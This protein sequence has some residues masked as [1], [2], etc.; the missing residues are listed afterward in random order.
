MKTVLATTPLSSV[1]FYFYITLMTVLKQCLELKKKEQYITP[2]TDK[3]GNVVEQTK[4]SNPS[5]FSL[6][7]GLLG[8]VYY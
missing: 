4:D 8:L 3:D 1:Y 2:R 5:F 6:L 7:Y